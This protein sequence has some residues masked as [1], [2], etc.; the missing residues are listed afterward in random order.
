MSTV[1]NFCG[2]MSSFVSV[3]HGFMATEKNAFQEVKIKKILF[4]IAAGNLKKNSGRKL[5]GVL[6]LSLLLTGQHGLFI[7]PIN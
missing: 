2:F 6:Y 5:Q 7:L 3:Y 1:V 4:D